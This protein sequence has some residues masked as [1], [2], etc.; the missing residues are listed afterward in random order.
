[1]RT[2][3]LVLALLGA[4]LLLHAPAQGAENVGPSRIALIPLVVHSADDR[5]YLRNGLRDMIRHRFAAIDE[6]ELIMI[7]DESRATSRL[8]EALAI[9]REVGAD[10]VFFGSFTR[11][12][13]GASLDVQCASTHAAEG[14]APLREIFVYSGN[15]GDVIPDL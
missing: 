9:G 4:T 8:P 2:W 1:M 7:E 11:F 5:A 6:V 3:M 14:E 10:F 12:G 13:S 15:V